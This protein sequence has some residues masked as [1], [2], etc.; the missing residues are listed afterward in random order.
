MFARVIHLLAII[1]C[2][3]GCGGPTTPSRYSYPAPLQPYG[4]RQQQRPIHPAHTLPREG[5]W[6]VACNMDRMTDRKT[7]AATLEFATHDLP[8][9]AGSLSTDDGGKSYSIVSSPQP[10]FAEIRINRNPQHLFRCPPYMPGCQLTGADATR[11]TREL[12]GAST[13]LIRVTSPGAHPP[14]IEVDVAADGFATALAEANSQL[15]GP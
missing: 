1:G 9:I 5:G 4:T 13:M 12:Q 10:L 7:C 2:L 14:V 3:A 11:L 8:I 15:G 6:K